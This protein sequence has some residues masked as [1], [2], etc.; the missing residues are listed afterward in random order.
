MSEKKPQRKLFAAAI[1]AVLVV[2]GLAVFRAVD[3]VQQ[4]N[5]LPEK[6]SSAAQRNV[7]QQILL[8][9]LA[10]LS[11]AAFLLFLYIKAN[12][13][14]STLQS[15]LEQA[16]QRLPG[17]ATF[18]FDQR[19]E[20][21]TLGRL[22]LALNRVSLDI[23]ESRRKEKLLIERAVDVICVIDTDARIVSVNNA[24]QKAWG[25]TRSEL[26]G[27]NLSVLLDNSES[28]R[29][30]S[31]ILGG[32]QSI[33]KVVFESQVRA[34]DGSLIDVI[35]TGHWSASEGGLFC[36]VHDISQQKLAEKAVRFSEQRLRATLE[37]LPAA[38]LVADSHNRIEF[39]NRAAVHLLGYQADAILRLSIS[40]VFDDEF[41]ESE[42]S[43]EQAEMSVE[44]EARTQSGSKVA[45]GLSRTRIN[46]SDGEK[47]LCVFLDRR[48]ERELERTKR[49]LTAMFTHD[50]KTP[51][52]AML[53]IFALLEDGVCGTIS[54]N[55][56]QLI[57]TSRKQLH[58]IVCLLDDMLQVAAIDATSFGLSCSEVS[59]QAVALHAVETMRASAPGREFII[60]AEPRPLI[61]LADE[62]RL[63]QV[64]INLLSN[65]VKYSSAHSAIT[66]SLRGGNGCVITSVTDTGR[67]I[68]EEKLE[69]I[70]ERFAQ[71][72]PSDAREHGGYGLGLAI[73]KEIVERH[74]GQIGVESE[75]GKGSTLWFSIP[76][77][78]PH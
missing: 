59:L 52:T 73:C 67:G 58:N 62:Q 3:S 48:A 47:L 69:R 39:A 72:E 42:P 26:V 56:L 15:S 1:T 76:V 77:A 25:Y 8:Q 31:Q 7:Q 49:E 66:V 61:C 63:N 38:V 34:R 4:L 5:S 9:L 74:G 44:A 29:V 40:R 23:S 46:M 41:T 13:E 18:D 71:V 55:G 57:A 45:V 78:E 75:V 27:N 32:I 30:T 16:L 22:D 14:V 64:L 2:I 68:P 28:Q 12:R 19:S 54:E 17:D 53:G 51:L 20:L 70:F 43:G 60:D 65:A 36:I 24:C 21:N 35:W 37:S 11:A 10:E 6:Y 50:L 33:D